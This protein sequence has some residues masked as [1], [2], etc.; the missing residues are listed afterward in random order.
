MPTKNAIIKQLSGITFAAKAD[1]NHWV[2]VDGPEGLHGSNAA[3]RPKELLLF[4]L[5]GCTASDVVSILTKKRV[6]FDN[7]EIYLEANLG[8][9]HPQV[10]T[11]IYIE[12]VVYGD[13][14]NP[15]DVEH[16]IEL[17]VTKYCSILAMLRG[18]VNI[19]HSYRVESLTKQETE[20]AQ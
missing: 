16:A 1:S 3:S 17:S 15:A 19:T 8:E 6:P 14:I 20:F 2:M 9:E 7:F 11:D 18:N 4:A 12:Y 5:G 13:E 10:F